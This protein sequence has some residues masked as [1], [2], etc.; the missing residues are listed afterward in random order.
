MN[1]L[2][3]GT[4]DSKTPEMDFLRTAVEQNGLG[5]IAVDSSCLRDVGP[6]W[7]DVRA[8]EVANEAGE[9]FDAVSRLPRGQ[10]IEV[11]SRG[12]AAI[13]RR[14]AKTGQIEGAI[15]IGGANGTLMASRVLSVLPR[16]LPKVLVSAAAAINLR[17]IIGSTDIAVFNSVCDVSLNEFTKRVFTNAA[18]A[19]AG[20]VRGRLPEKRA[21]RGVVGVSMLGLTQGLMNECKSELEAG[22]YDVMGFHANGYGGKALEE[23]IAGGEVDAVLDLTLNEVMNNLL[24]GVFDAGP[25]RLEAAIEQEIPMVLA[26]GAVDFVN[27]WSD[28]IPEK[29]RGRRLWRHNAQNTLMRTSPEENYI[30]GKA[31]G[32]KL[33]R[34]RTS[35]AVLIPLRGFSDLDRLNGP[36]EWFNAECE[37][38]FC[39]GLKELV[40]NPGVGIEEVDAHINSPEFAARVVNRLLDLMP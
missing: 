1:V 13:A 21:A 28:Q 35:C 27:F 8:T 9:P 22:G 26:P 31:I 37:G 10:A 36:E 24:G 4:F 7:V 3:F 30:C 38:A 40:G 39:R 11:M 34:C 23:M 5:A 15:C 17:D 33:N 19:L 18:N 29:Y 32:E 20:M 16:G 12:L 14:L 6:E 25:Q 2:L